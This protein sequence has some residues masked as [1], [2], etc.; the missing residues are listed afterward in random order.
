[1]VCDA[2]GGRLL[3]AFCILKG[4]SVSKIEEESWEKS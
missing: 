3:K 4:P 2:P 1:M